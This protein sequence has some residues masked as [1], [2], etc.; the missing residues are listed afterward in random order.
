MKKTGILNSDLSS[1]VASMGHT[2]L[3]VVCDSG[4][5]IPRNVVRIDLALRQGS[6]GIVETISEMAREL[7]V[8]KITF[9]LESEDHCA[10]LIG[11]VKALFPDASHEGIAHAELKK[12]ASNSVAVVRTG[13]CIPYSN[14]ILHA[15]VAF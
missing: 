12:L 13:E 3:I 14:I 5:P 15:G 2:D 10:A 9:A 7:E 8:E 4:Y 1:V 11:E 6:P